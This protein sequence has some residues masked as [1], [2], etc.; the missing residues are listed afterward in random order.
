MRTKKNRGFA[1]QLKREIKDLRQG[2]RIANM[3]SHRYQSLLSRLITL[4]RR[5]TI[6]EAE[7]YSMRCAGLYPDSVLVQTMVREL[8]EDK[9]FMKMF[10]VEK[11]IRHGGYGTFGTAC[12]VSCQILNQRNEP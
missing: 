8:M 4:S 7:E 3:N 11:D 1:R 2:L 12:I 5:Y 9:E 10:K 6:S